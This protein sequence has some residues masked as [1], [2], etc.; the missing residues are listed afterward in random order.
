MTLSRRLGV[1][2]ILVFLLTSFL[3][4]HRFVGIMAEDGFDDFGVEEDGDASRRTLIGE[5][6][7]LPNEAE[8]DSQDAESIRLVSIGDKNAAGASGSIPVPH[9]HVSFCKA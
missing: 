2:P 8:A 3:A 4:L 5:A 1:G 7:V 6:E 9:I